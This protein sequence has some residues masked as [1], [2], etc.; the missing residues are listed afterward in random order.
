MCL[1]VVNCWQRP[2]VPGS[3]GPRFQ[4]RRVEHTLP[5]HRLPSQRRKVFTEP[6]AVGHPAGHRLTD[7]VREAAT[8]AGRTVDFTGGLHQCGVVCCCR[9]LSCDGAVACS[10]E[11]SPLD[12]IWGIGLDEITARATAPEHWPGQNLLGKALTRAREHIK[13]T[14]AAK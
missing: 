1:V 12:S 10:V 11:A 9:N 13:A 8:A 6:G 5:R 3:Q 14:F 7:P 4:R 2:K